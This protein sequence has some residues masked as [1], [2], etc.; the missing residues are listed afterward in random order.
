M[1]D[2]KIQY[3]S[4]EKIEELQEEAKNIKEEKIPGIA[5]RIDEAKQMGDLSEN[6]EYHSA[7]EDMAW[8][9][10]RAK[11]IQH[12]L[13][14]SEIITKTSNSSGSVNIGS[15]VLV[16]FDGNTKEFTIVGPQEAEPVNGL[17]SNESPLGTAFLGK[18]KGDQVEVEAPAGVVKYKIK[19]VR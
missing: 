13:D 6:A 1:T 7:R 9:Q 2:Q 12:I 3:L 8:A 15:T 16:K 19:E 17:I 11:E 5:K 10:S 18:K 14:N 4:Q